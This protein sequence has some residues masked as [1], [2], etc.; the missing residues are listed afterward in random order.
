[1][2]LISTGKYL[3]REALTT[4]GAN[5]RIIACYEDEISLGDGS[6]TE[7]KWLLELE[8]LKPLVMNSTNIKAAVDC[9][10]TAETDEWVG[11]L[12]CAYDDDQIMFS[13]RKVGGVRLRAAKKPAKSSKPTT[14]DA[15]F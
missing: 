15:P 12:I 5:Y 8:N 13:G 11:Q 14:E 4:T 7:K 3:K 9:L 1:M 10:G 2:A 6:G